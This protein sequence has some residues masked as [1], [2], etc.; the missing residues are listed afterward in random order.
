MYSKWL[1]LH[2]NTPT[3]YSKCTEISTFGLKIG[4]ILSLQISAETSSLY[5][6]SFGSDKKIIGYI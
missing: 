6:G 2:S 3:V 4:T 1:F 5:N